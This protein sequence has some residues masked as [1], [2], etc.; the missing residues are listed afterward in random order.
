MNVL[1][2]SLGAGI[3]AHLSRNELDSVDDHVNEGIKYDT[4]PATLALEDA[5]GNVN[6]KGTETIVMDQRM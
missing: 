1:G 2:D 5:N 6:G 3:V 4:S